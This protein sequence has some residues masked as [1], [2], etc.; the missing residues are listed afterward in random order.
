MPVNTLAEAKKI[1][2]HGL[3]AHPMAVPSR[4]S[5]E[6]AIWYLEV[7]PGLRG[8][9]HTVDREEVFVVRSGRMSAT[10]GGDPC[11]AGPGDVVIVPPGVPFS[12]LNDGSEPA[13]LVVCT[14]VGVRA[15]LN[16][17]TVVPPWSE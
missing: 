4:G 14:S 13:R 2:F 9:E 15:T 3:T 12:M 10:I 16:G 11:E 5:A 8:E 7:P 1:E 17:R 6:L